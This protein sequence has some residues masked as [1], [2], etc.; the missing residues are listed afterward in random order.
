MT[1]GAPISPDPL[2]TARLPALFIADLHLSAARP[3][4]AA[5]FFDFL[6]GPARRAGS[7]FILG[8]LFEYWAGDDDAGS[9]FN[10]KVCL[11]LRELAANGIAAFFMPGN[12]DLLAGDG[13]AA[14]SG[15]HLLPDPASVRFGAQTLLLS[16]GDALCTDDLSYQAYR[17]QVHDPVW[18]TGFL[19]QPLDTRREFIEQV[20]NRS[21][22]AKRG[23]RA[24]IMDVNTDAVANLLRA[25]GYPALIHGHTHRPGHHTY[26]L[27]GHRCERYVLA[28]WHDHPAWL[29]Y[30]YAGFSVYNHIPATKEE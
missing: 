16:H 11:A 17:Q 10:Q 13:L 5:A 18:Q 25:H 28:D 29:T 30:D 14:S 21:E 2:S 3:Q 8:D 23:K 20:R 7:L 26:M 27:D 9:P 19:A 12:R 6:S 4:T 22:T 15:M 1:G 24:D